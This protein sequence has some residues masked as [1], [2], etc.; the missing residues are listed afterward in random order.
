MLDSLPPN[1]RAKVR[2]LLRS[3]IIVDV[4]LTPE[5][6]QLIVAKVAS[7]RF[8]SPS[9]VICEG[10]RLLQEQD[11]HQAAQLEDLLRQI[12]IGLDQLDR[13]EGIPGDEVFEELRRMSD[14]RRG[15]SA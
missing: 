11:E 2:Y 5:L 10:L 15:K 13:G 9:D 7:G 3:P 12:G 1:G 8:D 14:Q 4:T 6:E